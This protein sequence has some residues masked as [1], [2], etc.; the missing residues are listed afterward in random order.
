T[1]RTRS[2]SPQSPPKHQRRQ[3]DHLS[4]KER[5]R[6]RRPGGSS[7]SR[8]SQ[9]WC[10]C[11]A[12]T[13]SATASATH[14]IRPSAGSAL[15]APPANFTEGALMPEPVLSIRDLA[16]QFTTDD[17]IVRAVDGVTYD[18]FPGET[19]GIVGES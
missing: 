14:S 3:S 5:T 19:L 9:S 16:V 18:V 4:P 13:S 6:C 10:S 17:G 12:S 1:C 2:Q 8:A 7:S 15:D 11:S